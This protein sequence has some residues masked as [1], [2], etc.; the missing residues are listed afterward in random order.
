MQAD[1]PGNV[2]A[3]LPDAARKWVAIL[4]PLSIALLYFSLPHTLEDFAAGEP[5]KKGIPPPVLSAVVSTLIAA[6]ALGLFWL[7][8]GLR[9]GLWVHAVLGVIWP[10]AAGFAQLPVILGPDPY[11]DGAI[12]VLY[13]V[14]LLTIAPSI[15]VLSVLGLRTP[16]EA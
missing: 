7:G 4:V 5:L 3:A 9:R 11:R 2:T 6:Q 1:P 16:A 15:T 10:L 8:R 12:S 14:G 13:V